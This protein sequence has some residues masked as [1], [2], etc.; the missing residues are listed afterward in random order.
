[1]AGTELRAPLFAQA[2]RY[3]ALDFRNMI[4][5]TRGHQV[6]VAGREALAVT[7]VPNGNSIAIASGSVWLPDDVQ[8]DHEG[9]VYFAHLDQAVTL[10]IRLPGAGGKTR[11]DL[12]VA[13]ADP[14]ATETPAAAFRSTADR[15]M[16]PVWYAQ[17]GTP[18]STNPDS[19]SVPAGGT[20]LRSDYT[21]GWTIAVLEPSA[22]GLTDWKIPDNAVVLAKV[23]S[24]ETGVSGVQDL[25]FRDVSDLIRG[26]FQ[27]DT[28]PLRHLRT[29]GD[30]T[31]GQLAKTAPEGSLI[32]DH[33]AKTMV[34][35]TDSKAGQVRGMVG[36]RKTEGGR[37]IPGWWVPSGAVSWEGREV[38]RVEFP[39]VP[40]ARRVDVIYRLVMQNMVGDAAQLWY[41]VLFN[42][43]PM[44]QQDPHNPGGQG[45]RVDVQRG[46][47]RD[48][49]AG[50]ACTVTVEAGCTSA[51]DWRDGNTLIVSQDPA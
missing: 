4:G 18:Y 9:A 33:Q 37:M 49:P 43:Q 39:A 42:G 11:T 31:V 19:A 41:R 17:D 28:T 29:S 36:S 51:W 46:H 10:A 45:A 5:R 24:A 20:R 1:M 21:G 8:A 27:V 44:I 12:V 35:V 40:F 14:D 47:A 16:Q 25:R 38:A 48:L 32:F 30:Q 3:D 34:F 13:Y 26:Q 50:Q 6:G 22:P 2:G 15:F 23:E 7:Q